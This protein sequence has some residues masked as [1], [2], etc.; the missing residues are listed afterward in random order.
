MPRLRF[1]ALAVLAGLAAC[2]RVEV[3][4]NTPS[5]VSIR[6]GGAM[7][8]D[9]ALAEANRLCAAHGK[10]AQLRSEDEKGLLEHYANFNCVSR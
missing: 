9:D 6:Y 4:E 3:L 5:S 10:I 1:F 2:A 8:E 7:T